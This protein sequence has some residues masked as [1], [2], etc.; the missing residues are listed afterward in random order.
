MRSI[1]VVGDLLEPGLLK[2]N[3]PR[4]VTHQSN[5]MTMTAVQ[6]LEHL[7]RAPTHSWMAGRDYEQREVLS[8]L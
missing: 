6:A 5:E 2:A 4:G 1:D 7:A 3:G 8:A